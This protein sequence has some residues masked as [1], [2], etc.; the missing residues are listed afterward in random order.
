M[1]NS[2]LPDLSLFFVYVGATGREM[3][4]VGLKDAE[5]VLSGPRGSGVC[6]RSPLPF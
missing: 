2:L 6:F 5:G 4:L 3:A 1:D